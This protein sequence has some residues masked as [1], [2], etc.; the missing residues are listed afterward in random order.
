MTIA[1]ALEVKRPTLQVP[2]LVADLVAGVLELA[3]NI[4][5]FEPIL[6]RSRVMMMGDNY[7]YNIEKAKRELGYEP[8]VGLK[9]GIMRTVKY[10][11]EEGLF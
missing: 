6:T 5:R 10:Y 1:D 2:R 3:G 4:F 9:K 8:S 7:G 11:E